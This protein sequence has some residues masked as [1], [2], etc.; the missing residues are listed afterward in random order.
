MSVSGYSHV[1]LSVGVA[2]YEN[3]LV[4]V[5]QLLKALSPLLLLFH[6]LLIVFLIPS[7]LLLIPF[8]HLFL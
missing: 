4:A 6:N 2:I 5:E 1:A 8:S 3:W 7:G